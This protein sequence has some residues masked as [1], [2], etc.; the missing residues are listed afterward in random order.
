MKIEHWFTG[1]VENIA[2]PLNAGRVQVRIYEYHELDDVNS[3][4]SE[5]LPWATPLLPITSAS[6]TSIGT[7]ATGLM[8]GS[9]VFGFFRDA[10]QQDPVILA[11]IPGVAS[12][13]GADIPRDA[14]SS[15][16]GIAYSG[17]TNTSQLVE[18]SPVANPANTSALDGESS[19]QSQSST[20]S[21]AEVN[22]FVNKVLSES[23]DENTSS[24]RSIGGDNIQGIDDSEPTITSSPVAGNNTNTFNRQSFPND[25]AA[26]NAAELPSA[27]RIDPNAPS[28]LPP[29]L[30]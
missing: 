28:L 18:N 26:N 11:S 15:S 8:V 22:N 13:N 29:L 25:R 5:N 7:G 21:S 10:D 27:G 3:I 17:A 1:I 24:T 9:W 4:P 12:V 6:N 2:D 19:P 23:T 30:D 14:S 16:V 20:N